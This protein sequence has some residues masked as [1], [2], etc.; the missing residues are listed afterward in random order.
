MFELKKIEAEWRARMHKA[1]SF[2][3]AYDYVDGISPFTH[4]QGTFC[5]WIKPNYVSSVQ[6]VGSSSD[7]ASNS[8]YFGFLR[9]DSTGKPSIIV[10]NDGNPYNL[11]LG[12]T[13]LQTGKWY[14]ICTLSTGS[15]YKIYVNGREETLTVST[16]SNDG[17]WLD[18]VQNRDNTV[19]GA[20]KRS[21]ISNFFNGTIDEVRIYN[22]ALS[23]SEIKYLYHNPFDPIDP[24]HLVL[25]LNPAGI[26][27]ANSKWWDLSGKGNH[28][29]IH[30][31][32]EK[33]LIEEEVIVK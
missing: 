27:I 7:E 17:A 2:D 33:T 14:H 8:Y 25:W 18:K 21:S 29:T 23:P 1:L 10:Y 26:D 11:I 22:R 30:G 15:E 24:E 12:S 9:I 31:A 5:A 6:Y 13:V 20:L 19:I 28:G 16:G 32:V 4:S 3:G